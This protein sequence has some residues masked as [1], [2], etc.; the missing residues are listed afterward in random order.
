MFCYQC[1]QT[2]RSGERPGCFASVGNCGKDET[3]ADL[4]DLLLYMLQGIG[5]YATR[6][7]AL[8][9]TDREVDEF[10]LY[11]AFTTLTNVNFN[12]SRFVTL[13]AQA[14]ELR[15]RLRAL[16]ENAAGAGAWQASGPAAF[17]PGT[18]MAEL[19]EQ[20]KA[21]GILDA[22]ASD[23][24]VGLRA[25]NLYGFKGVCAYAHHACVL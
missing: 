7:R 11:A 9:V 13:I 1:E 19:T 25:L 5:Q 12:A 8:G 4:Q 24:I 14:A 16:Y 21:H 18:T 2:S 23:T 6:A 15:D 10:I 22:T 20:A 3:T 17:I